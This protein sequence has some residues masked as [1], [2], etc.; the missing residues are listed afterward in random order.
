MKIL[1]IDTETTGLT[2]GKCDP[3]QIAGMVEID[4]EIKEEFN[5]LSQPFDFNVGNIQQRALDV[6]GYTL[7]QLRSE[8]FLPPRTAYSD[9]LRI[10]GRYV[11]RFDK[12]DKFWMAGFNVRFDL[13]MVQGW[14]ENVHDKY[15]GSWFEYK[16]LDVMQL[17]FAEMY[18]G[19]LTGLDSYRLETIARHY[20]I[21]INAHDAISD[22]KA[23]REL[24][25]RLLSANEAFE[26]TCIKCGKML[27][28]VDVECGDCI[29]AS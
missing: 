29:K 13:D 2:P 21:E 9:F 23:S 5:I 10:L 27:E 4:G 24:F 22:I 12:R 18:K 6:H 16:V 25:L 7:E 26:T 1:W 20:G 14:F 3:I 28:I 19:R 15:F 17:A 11:D 8:P